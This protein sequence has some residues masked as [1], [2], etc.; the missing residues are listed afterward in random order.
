MA[1]VD[2]PAIRQPTP[3]IPSTVGSTSPPTLVTV[4]STATPTST[5]PPTPAQVL[6]RALARARACSGLSILPTIAPISLDAP[7]LQPDRTERDGHGL[8]RA[9][10]LGGP[11]QPDHG[12]DLA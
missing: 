5:R 8:H 12:R 1:P 7:E 6:R 10:D 2:T 4:S 9:G 3:T 11:V